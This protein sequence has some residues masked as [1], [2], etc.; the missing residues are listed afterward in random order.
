MKKRKNLN[1]PPW[2]PY[3]SSWLKAA[4]LAW[5]L[6]AIALIIDRMMLWDYHLTNL[7]ENRELLV[8]FTLVILLLPIPA[9][10][11]AHNLLNLFFQIILPI[12]GRASRAI[13]SKLRLKTQ[14]QPRF[15]NRTISIFPTLI[16]WWAG[17]YS[18]LV[19][20]LSTIITV[21]V[22]TLLFSWVDLSYET[23]SFYYKHLWVINSLDW[24][25]LWISFGF[26]WI[27]TAAILYQFEHLFKQ[28]ISAKKSILNTSNSNQYNHINWEQVPI[29][30]EL[31]QREKRGKAGKKTSSIDIHIKLQEAQVLSKQTAEKQANISLLDRRKNRWS[32]WKG[33][34]QILTLLIISLLVGGIY[35]VYMRENSR[36]AA[37]V[38]QNS[39]PNSSKTISA[40]VLE[41]E[42]SPTTS[43]SVLSPSPLPSKTAIL[44]PPDPFKMA[45]NRATNAAEMT[46][47]ANTRIEWEA[48][49]SQWQ[50]AVELMKVVPAFHPNYRTARQKAIEYQNNANYA[51]RVAANTPE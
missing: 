10:A 27:T 44:Q 20:I 39:P 34:Q 30:V 21:M 32:N 5:F 28:K 17:L 23:I 13:K 35:G 40:D 3:P 36:E 48:V 42:R 12:L 50:D 2:F 19:F 8:L 43:N 7:A 14:K 18:W 51:R 47:E 16:N 24:L 29:I 37:I 15:N 11:L 41:K 4:V 38:A 46:Q 31:N 33:W 25:Y 22:Y 45:V 9:I 26:I 1:L 49:A 6:M